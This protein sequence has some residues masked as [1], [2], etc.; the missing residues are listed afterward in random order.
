MLHAL[1]SNQQIRKFLNAFVG[2]FYNYDLQTRVVI[3]VGV[4]GR[5]DKIMMGVLQVHQTLW[6]QS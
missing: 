4:R 3:Q 2:P 1:G 6:Q 5:D